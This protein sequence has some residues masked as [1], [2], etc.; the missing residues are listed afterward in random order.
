[1]PNDSSIFRNKIVGVWIYGVVD[2]KSPYVWSACARY[3]F[4]TNFKKSGGE[5]V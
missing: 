4:C 3:V 5:K 2:P 1:M